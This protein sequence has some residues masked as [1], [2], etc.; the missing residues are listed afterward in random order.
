MI[1][2][3]THSFD[4]EVLWSDRPTLVDFWAPWCKP[5]V[6]LSHVL[7]TLAKEYLHINFAKLNVAE[8]SVIATRYHITSLPTLV[9]F[10][11][12]GPILQIVGNCSTSKIK[13]ALEDINE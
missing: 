6:A 12:G 8:S 3:D 10:Q 7:E 11:S 9:L 2:V 13:Q 5:C 1:D 4:R